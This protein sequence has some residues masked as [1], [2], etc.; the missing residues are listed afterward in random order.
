M[1][2]LYPLRLSFKL[3]AVAPQIY[4]RDSMGNDLM[5][6]HQKLFKLKESIG[7]YSNSSKSQ[8]LFKIG[9]DRIIDW[10][11]RYNFTNSYD[12][13][14]FGSIKREGMKSL[15]RSSY[16]IFDPNGQPTHFL[17]EVDP[18]VKVAD[19]CLTSIPVLGMFSGYFFHPSYII[20]Q[21]GTNQPIMKLTKQP[22]F[23]E[24]VFSLE[25]LVSSMPEDEEIRFV[26]SFIMMLLLERQRG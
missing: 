22:A 18:W 1:R 13:R 21:N 15:W 2:F 24:G 5:Y 25:P 17:K 11:A 10:S 6:I 20:Y 9:A 26:L 12:G 14:A 19:G 7:V 16:L 3:I 4:L 8:E 23:W